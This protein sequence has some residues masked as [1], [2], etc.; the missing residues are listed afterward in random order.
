MDN[1]TIQ[2]YNQMAKEYDEETSDFWE[3]FPK[4]F[5]NKFIELTKG[6]VL[7]VGSGPGRDALLLRDCGLEVVCVDASG[8]MVEMTKDKGLESVVGD[9]SDLP[10]KE[11]TFDGVW[12][13]TSLLHTPKSEIYKPILEINRVLKTSGIFGLG[14]IEGDSEEYRESSGMNMPRLFS[15]YP[16][17]E[18]EKLLHIYD[19]EILYFEQFKPAS[20]NYLNFIA[21]KK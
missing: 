17:S 10:F 2:T 6:K 1:K 15:Y 11:N 20:K 3:R 9:F 7:D 4:T 8:S 5:I 18:I 13:Y 19:F 21:R 12:A 14:M 16:K